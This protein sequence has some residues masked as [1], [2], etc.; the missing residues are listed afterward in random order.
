MES[1]Y[2]PA[3]FSIIIELEMLVCYNKL[4][5]IEKKADAVS[6]VIAL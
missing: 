3:F 1:S 5:I 6:D 2:F 4:H